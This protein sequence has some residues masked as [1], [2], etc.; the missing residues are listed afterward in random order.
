MTKTAKLDDYRKNRKPGQQDAFP[1]SA[2][3]SNY[4]VR[5][6]RQDF[7]MTQN[8]FAELLEIHPQNLSQFETGRNPVTDGL[9]SKLLLLRDISHVPGIALSLI[10][11]VDHVSGR[12][13]W[14]MAEMLFMV[15]E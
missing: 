13:A 7:N 9:L 12:R 4:L 5:E 15:I 14:L 1:L 10:Y 6:I 11:V 2:E 3:L 8:Q